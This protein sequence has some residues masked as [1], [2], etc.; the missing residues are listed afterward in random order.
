MITEKKENPRRNDRIESAYTLRMATIA[1][2]LSESWVPFTYEYDTY[3]IWSEMEW[4][5]EPKSEAWNEMQRNIGRKLRVEIRNPYQFSL[6]I[7]DIFYNLGRM[8]IYFYKIINHI[9][10]IN[11]LRELI[12]NN[13]LYNIE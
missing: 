9:I 11:P 7:I 12:T 13:L 2:K 8:F 5:A 10:V 3:E 1:K 6:K 4:K